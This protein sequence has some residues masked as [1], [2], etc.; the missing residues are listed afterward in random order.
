[1]KNFTLKSLIAVASMT[2]AAGIASAQALKV[3]IPFSFRAGET[4]MAPGT[5]R[6]I[7]NSSALHTPAIQIRRQDEG[8][9]IMMLANARDAETQ[10]RTAGVPKVQFN[11][12]DGRCT[13]ARV[14]DGTS[15]DA[16]E[17]RRSRRALQENAGVTVI[18]LAA[19]RVK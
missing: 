7:A 10:W 14:Y 12:L 3:E 15:R 11:C 8:G 16:M 13:L 6:V 18:T 9:G 17:L 5:Y 4:L 1:M 19:V 2:V